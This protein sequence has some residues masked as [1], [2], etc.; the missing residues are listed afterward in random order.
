MCVVQHPYMLQAQHLLLA[1][2]VA[3]PIIEMMRM[4]CWQSELVSQ[5]TN[6][7]C[8]DVPHS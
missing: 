2:R 8:S 7:T 6:A 1:S 3:S 5:R 4:T